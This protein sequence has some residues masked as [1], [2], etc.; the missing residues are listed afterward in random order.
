M[1][2]HSDPCWDLC[3]ASVARGARF[4]NP[5][6]Q[7][8]DTRATREQPWRQNGRIKMTEGIKPQVNMGEVFTF[9]G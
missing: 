5:G 9:W 2:G 6:G 4:D 7:G 1:A 3:P 8:P